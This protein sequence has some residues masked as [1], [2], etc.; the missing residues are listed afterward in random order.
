MNINI[1]LSAAAVLLVI[2]G[3]SSGGGGSPAP[4]VVTPPPVTGPPTDE[5][6]FTKLT[7]RTLDADGDQ[8]GLDTYD[9]IRAFGGDYI[10]GPIEAPDL[11]PINHPEVKHIYEDFDATV[12]NHFVFII[13]RDTDIDRDRVE[14]DDRQRNEIKTYDKSEEAVK[15]YEGETFIYRWKFRINADMEVSTRFSHFFQLKAVGGNDS[16][17]I[18]TISGAERSG[19]DGIEVRY[20]PLQQDTIL[21]RQN[22]SMVT[23][24]WLEAYCRVT[25]SDSGDLRLIVT[26]LSDDKVIFN[27]D[28][29]GLDLWRGENASHFVR[30]KWGIYRSIFDF[31]N[32]RPDEENVRFANFSI[33]EVMPTN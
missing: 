4:P 20:S 8:S 9:L 28:E 3:C 15:G 6:Q 25:F 30:P 31:D 11:Y 10:P 14:N 16:H 12:G 29:T 22:W 26:R 17:P 7:T 21:E 23:G 32:L 18:L 24:E 5:V 19:E 2:V 1:S 33:S 13:H 27:I